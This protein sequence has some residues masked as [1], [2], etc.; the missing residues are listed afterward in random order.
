MTSAADG[1]EG[2]QEGIQGVLVRFELLLKVRRDLGELGL[3]AGALQGLI[4]D[5]DGHGTCYRHGAP[6]L[7]R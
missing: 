4:V 5:L 7:K 3:E 2:R 1:W 6:D